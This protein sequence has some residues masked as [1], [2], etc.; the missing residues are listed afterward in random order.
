M[1]SLHGNGMLLGHI[2]PHVHARL[3]VSA[4][5]NE[6]M[7]ARNCRV[8]ACVSSVTHAGCLAVWVYTLPEFLCCESPEARCHA[9]ENPARI[10]P[11]YQ[12]VY[13]SRILSFVASLIVTLTLIADRTTEPTFSFGFGGDAPNPL[14]KDHESLGRAVA[15]SW[16]AYLFQ[17]FWDQGFGPEGFGKRTRIPQPQVQHQASNPETLNA[18]DDARCATDT[19]WW[20]IIFRGSVAPTRSRVMH[21]YL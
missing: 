21:V 13:R 16:Y 20:Q 5:M 4:R 12:P 9:V 7:H 6:T 2:R 14:R 10:E 1:L 15:F 8:S 19:G 17:G 3:F 11:F 18:V